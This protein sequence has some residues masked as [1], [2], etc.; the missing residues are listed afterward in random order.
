[1]V[2]QQAVDLV[3]DRFATHGIDE[4]NSSVSCLSRIVRV[5]EFLSQSLVRFFS[6]CKSS[7]LPS[8]PALRR[9]LSAAANYSCNRMDS[10][11]A[12]A[13]FF[14]HTKRSVLTMDLIVTD[15]TKCFEIPRH[16][17]S[18]LGVMGDVMQFQM[19]RM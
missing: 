12:H 19:A 5:V 10:D 6:N 7:F 9:L 8:L 15:V 16:V 2:G 13:V 18:S 4:L 11:S 14:E 17:F 3:C 1:M